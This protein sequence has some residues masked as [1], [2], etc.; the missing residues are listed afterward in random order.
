M[1]PTL[2]TAKLNLQGVSWQQ[3]HYLS[4]ACPPK[5]DDSKLAQSFELWKVGGGVGV[6]QVHVTSSSY[7]GLFTCVLSSGCV[8]SPVS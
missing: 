3:L 7:I 4:Q 5:E 2:L 6:G 8:H 1:F